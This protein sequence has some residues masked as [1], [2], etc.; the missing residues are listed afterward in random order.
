MKDRTL[1]GQ[2]N[3]NTS[4]RRGSILL[5]TLIA[6]MLI[7][8]MGMAILSQTQTGLTQTKR[9]QGNMLAFNLAES[10]ADRAL[11]WLK[12]QSSPPSGLSSFN[13]FGGAVDLVTG[14]YNVTITPD[15]NNLMAVLKKYKIVSRGTVGTQ[16]EQVELTVRQTSF[17]KYAYFTDQEVSSVSSSRIWFYGGDRIRGP[18][19][20]NSVNSTDFQ[21][22]WSAANS[23]T[24]IF[25]GQ[26]TSAGD[27]INYSPRDPV[28]ESEF[29]KMF[30]AGSRGY[31]LGVDYIP[32]P[33]STSIQQVAAWGPN[34]AYPTTTGVYTPAGGGIYIRGSSTVTMQVDG[35]GNQQFRVVQG[36]TTTIVTFDVANNRTGRKVGSAAT[37]YTAGLG[38]GV[39]YSTGTITMTAG[40]IADNRVSNGTITNRNAFTIAT[41][42][43]VDIEF[44]GAVRHNTAYNPALTPYDAANL[45]PGTLGLVS[46][47]VTVQTGAP[48]NMEIDA[49][50]LAGSSTQPGSFSVEDYDSKSPTGTLKVVGGVIQRARGPVGTI[51]G[52]GNLNTGYAK[53]YVYDARMAD[54]PPPY[55]PTTGTYDKISW[56]RLVDGT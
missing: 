1:L 7:M 41:D 48:Q 26:V 51:N 40:T 10:G 27:D 37:T 8:V 2:P 12:N 49:V 31:E 14:T 46:R 19:H 47:N 4:T 53:D 50:I 9:V 3:W 38:S 36:S 20:S 21:I 45:V 23:A 28:T 52:S 32:M 18:A 15:S 6:M 25:E 39:V 24:P 42:P 30:R 43:G 35:S 33:T 13:P 11:R 17:G 54:N 29:T 22:N 5:T 56:R 55:F 34:G 16:Y 44:S